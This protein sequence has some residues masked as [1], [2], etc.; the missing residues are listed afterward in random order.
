MLAPLVLGRHQEVVDDDLAAVPEVA[1]LRLPGDQVARGLDRVAVLEAEARVLRE[2]RVADG[3]GAGCPDP[4]RPRGTYS[5]PVTW[6]TS[7][8]W[9]CENVPRRVSWPVTRTLV[10]SSRRVPKARASPRAQSISPSATI[11]SRCSNWRTSFGCMTK[12]VGHRAHDGGQPGEGAGVD[13]GVD[14]RDVQ[15]GDDEGGQRGLGLSRRLGL[16]PGLVE[17]RPAGGRRSRRGPARPPRWRCLPG[18]PATRCR[19]CAPS[20]WPR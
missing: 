11:L 6:S 20:A 7:T 1:E 18:A 10:P 15:V 3:E 5:A 8:A 13:S 2:E 9:R 4:S 14:G 16:G 12:P 19:A 17:R